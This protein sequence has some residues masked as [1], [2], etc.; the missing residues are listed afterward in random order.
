VT[1]ANTP[2]LEG[3]D[4]HSAMAEDG[5]TSSAVAMVGCFLSLLMMLCA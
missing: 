5:S 3:A 1:T 4:L 2:E